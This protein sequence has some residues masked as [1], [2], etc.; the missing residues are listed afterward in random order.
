MLYG[1]LCAITGAQSWRALRVVKAFDLNCLHN[2]FKKYSQHREG[3]TN[4]PCTFPA[5]DARCLRPVRH[6]EWYRE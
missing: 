4:S 3:F 2:H 1:G 5:V 6:D